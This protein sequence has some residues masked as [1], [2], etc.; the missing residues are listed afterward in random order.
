LPFEDMPEKGPDVVLTKTP[1]NAQGVSGIA[2]VERAESPDG[3]GKEL[4]RLGA[5]EQG[6]NIYTI[7]TRSGPGKSV[8]VEAAEFVKSI[9]VDGKPAVTKATN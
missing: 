2:V 7:V 8:P 6:P 3:K 5:V 1:I 9:R 4:S